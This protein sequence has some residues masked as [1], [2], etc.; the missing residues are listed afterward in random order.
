MS[1]KIR[2]P[3]KWENFI[4]NLDEINQTAVIRVLDEIQ[5]N[6]YENDGNV[7]KY[8]PNKVF[9][10][11]AGDYRI[12]YTISKKIKIIDIIKIGHRRNVYK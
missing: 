8:L 5:L 9:K 4:S 12:L 2:I 3:R 11:R 6:P 1:W 10:R 7:K